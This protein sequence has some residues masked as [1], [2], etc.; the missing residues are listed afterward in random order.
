MTATL[1][2]FQRDFAA[3]RAKADAGEAV[4]IEAAGQ[5]RYIFK[6]AETAP[7]EP[8]AAL[9]RRTTQGLVLPRDKRPLRRA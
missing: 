9:L 6:L 3:M 5:P 7:R 2:Q 1:R 4:L 8:L